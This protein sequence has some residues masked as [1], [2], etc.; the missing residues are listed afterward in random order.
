MSLSEAQESAE[1]WFSTTVTSGRWLSPFIPSGW[2]VSA[3]GRSQNVRKR[4]PYARKW[5]VM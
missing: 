3:A 2:G 5:L 4:G 1:A